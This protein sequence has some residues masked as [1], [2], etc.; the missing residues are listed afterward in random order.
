MTRRTWALIFLLAVVLAA[1]LWWLVRPLP[2]DEPTVTIP[3]PPATVASTATATATLAAVATVTATDAPT[4]VVTTAPTVTPT[5]LIVPTVVQPTATPDL[6]GHH[7]V[8]QGDTMYDIGLWW[9]RGQY[10]AWGED[11]WRPICDANPQIANCRMIY[12]GDVL[13]IPRLP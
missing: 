11:V 6:L 3:P 8:G 12:V 4:I 9:Y 1:L 5:P 2:P 10:F 7:R 13:A